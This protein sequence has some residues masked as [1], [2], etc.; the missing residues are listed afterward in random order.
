[1]SNNPSDSND[2]RDPERQITFKYEKLR[3]IGS[4]ILETASVTF[5]LLIAVRHFDA[6][7]TAKAL[8]AASTSIGF[9]LSPIAVNLVERLGIRTAQAA[10][11]LALL[12]GLGFLVTTIFPSLA[13]FVVGGVLGVSANS[14]SLP[15]VTHM[16]QENYPGSLLGRLFSR[17]VMI[18]IAVAAL[19]SELAGR[20]LT[21]Q[22]EYYQFLMAIFF[23]SSLYSAYC[24]SRCPSQ[25]IARG[26][27]RNPFSGMRFIRTDRVFRRTLI[28]WMLMGFANVMMVPLRIEYIANPSY[29]LSLSVSEIALLTGVIPNISRFIFSP[30]WG[31]LFDRINFFMLRISINVGF[32]IGILSFFTSDSWPGLILGAVLFGLSNAG[33]DIAG[34]LWVTKFAPPEKVA[35]YMGVHTFF[36]GVRGI[37]A[38]FTGFYLAQELT[39]ASLGLISAA[40]IGLATLLLVPEYC[41]EKERRA[42]QNGTV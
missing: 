25:V 20:A 34:N 33:G 5:L 31:A 36:M 23:L 38:P 15:L 40:M 41:T 13:L 6:G 24:L 2:S 29:G 21:G 22:L 35:E 26:P 39:L 19:F 4:G 14:I 27:A 1:M 8:V 10:A 17:T 16:L 7:P 3:A 32:A 37:V 30:F 42:A 28:C 11:A 12:S 18:R 9:L